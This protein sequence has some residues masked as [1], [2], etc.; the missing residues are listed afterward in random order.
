MYKI[1]NTFDLMLS[2]QPIDAMGQPAPV[3]GIPTWVVSDPA[4]ANIE[5]AADGLSAKVIPLVPSSGGFQVQVEC[6][7][8][9]GTGVRTLTGAIE[10]SVGP[11][12]AVSIGIAIGELVPKV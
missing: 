2:I 7:A 8:D 5:V 3:D 11:S 12:E 4:I 6:D 1:P 9:L 10:L